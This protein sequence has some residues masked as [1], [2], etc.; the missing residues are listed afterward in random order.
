MTIRN[1]TTN[2]ELP[3]GASGEICVRGPNVGPGYIA[4]GERGLQRV[5][6]WLQS[7]DQGSIDVDGVVTFEGLIKPMFTRNGFNI[8]PA[9]LM[10]V[11]GAMP[12]VLRVEV[13]GI[14]EPAKEHEI[15]VIVHGT[16]TAEAVQQWCELHLS[17][18]KQPSHI[19]IVA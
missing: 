11:I 6:G 9:E 12:G 10:H 14:P 18:Y 5:D 1:P 17:S 2:A 3:T 16:V 7:G 19:T 4:G 8:Y 13:L 15:D